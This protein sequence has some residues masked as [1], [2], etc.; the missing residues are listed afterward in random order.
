MIDKVTITGADDSTDIRWMRSVSEK[1][2]FAE[3][4]I[5]VS[6]SQMGGYR[7]P[8]LRWLGRL[9]QHQSELQTSV[10]VC[11]RWVRQICQGYWL[12][13]PNLE[14]LFV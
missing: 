9:A 5:L 3:W 13:F 6:K 14:F 2:P 1:F 4:G 12:H 8:S 11:G 7:F 10:H